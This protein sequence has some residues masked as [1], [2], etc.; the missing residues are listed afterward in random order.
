MAI[1]IC[2]SDNLSNTIRMYDLDSF[3]VITQELITVH[4]PFRSTTI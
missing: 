2:L 3:F 1:N 4:K